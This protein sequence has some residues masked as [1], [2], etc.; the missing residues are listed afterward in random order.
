[1]TEDTCHHFIRCAVTPEDRA[2]VADIHR[3]TPALM[4]AMLTG[5]CTKSPTK[6]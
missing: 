4:F 1:M 6:D 2:M 3:D 5:P